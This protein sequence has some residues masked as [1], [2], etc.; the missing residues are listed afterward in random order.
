MFNHYK[1]NNKKVP[2]LKIPQSSKSPAH[3]PWMSQQSDSVKDAVRLVPAILAALQAAASD[4]AKYE[5]VSVLMT[6][7]LHKKFCPGDHWTRVMPSKSLPSERDRP[8]GL[9]VEY[10]C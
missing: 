7:T 1:P 4:D 3:C 2:Q 5:V 10:Q 8:F 6:V 9:R